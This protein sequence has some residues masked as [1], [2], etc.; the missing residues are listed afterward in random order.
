MNFFSITRLSLAV[1]LHLL[2]RISLVSVPGLLLVMP[3][4]VH[5]KKTTPPTAKSASAKP[6]STLVAEDDDNSTFTLG[7]IE[8]THTSKAKRLQSKDVLTSVDIMGAEMISNQVANQSWEL[9]SRMPGLQITGFN[10]GTTSGKFSMRGFNGEGNINAVKLL[11]DGIPS[12]SNDG[13]MPFMDSVFP[14]DIQSIETVRGT[15]DARY[16]LHAIAGS[17]NINTRTGGNYTKGRFSYGS[18]NA[19]DAQ[20]SAG[21]E[22]G[23]LSQNYF[24]GYRKSDGYRDHA[25]LEK[26]T[27]SG[28]WFYTPD[29]GKF[30]V[31]LITRWNENTAQEA[32]YLTY[33]DSR[34]NPTM[35]N[36]YN[37]KD[38]DE[39]RT[40]QVS[41][42]LDVNLTED[43]FWSTKG[44]ANLFNDNRLVQFS[45]NVAQQERN[46]DEVQY[47]AIT[48]L[49]YHPKIA[50]LDDFSVETGFDVQQQDNKSTRY[51][52]PLLANKRQTRY[53]KFDFQIYGGYV[54][55]MIKPFKWLKI[56]PGFRVDQVSGNLNDVLNKTSS[57]VNNYG[58]IWQPKIGAVITPIDGYSLYGNWGRTFQVAVGAGTYITNP[59]MPDLPASINEGWEVGVKLQPFNWLEGRVAYWQQSATGE[60]S[61]DLNNPNNDS[62]NIGATKR[63]GVDV[64]LQMKPSD[65]INLWAS[66][67]L[68]KAIIKAAPANAKT[69]GKQVDHT[70]DYI[71]SAGVDYQILPDLKSSLWTTGQGN[72]FLDTAN[73]TQQFGEYALLNLALDY[74]VNKQVGLQFQVK[75]LTNTYW[76]YAWFDGTQTLHS[77]G[78][79]RAFY[80][81]V[82]VKFDY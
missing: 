37:A 81:A 51:T 3:I 9:F 26:Y 7:E 28:K 14:L 4:T 65:D 24:I 46:V 31:G 45:S 36:A 78:D 6:L 29:S 71:F 32:G 57:R 80:G 38:K 8:V 64:Q 55:T 39:R 66:Y 11:V 48:S 13:N 56:T 30:S 15:N 50:W 12:N 20:V 77:P 68:Q 82:N 17:A 1:K 21:L 40:G 27:F 23:G 41:G 59:K 5:A 53:Q 34:L 33:K 60:W 49:T 16:G 35:T 61:R 2:V 25:N 70:P 75:N 52:N 44:Y 74:Q 19:Y 22:K 69:V 43:L 54:Q 76:E 72:Y 47:G 10:Q 79:G 73:S 62:I 42:H 67:S 63:Q 58:A 18:F